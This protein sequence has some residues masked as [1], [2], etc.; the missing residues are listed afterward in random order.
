VDVGLI[1]KFVVGEV[2]APAALPTESSE[3]PP[4]VVAPAS[5]GTVFAPELFFTAIATL[6]CLSSFFT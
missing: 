2:T 4:V 5:S 1:L 6:L 3:L